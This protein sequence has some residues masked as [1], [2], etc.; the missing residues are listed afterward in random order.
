MLSGD[1]GSVVHLPRGVVAWSAV[2]VTAA[3]T[4]LASRHEPPRTA[5]S[6]PLDDAATHSPSRTPTVR[7]T[8]SVGFGAGAHRG[9]ER[10]SAT[11]SATPPSR[12]RGLSGVDHD[13]GRRCAQVREA[14]PYSHADAGR[15]R[16][17]GER[18]VPAGEPL[19]DVRRPAGPVT[20]T[21]VALHR[22]GGVGSHADGRLRSGGA[23][24]PAVADLVLLARTAVARLVAP[25]LGLSL[26]LRGAGAL[27]LA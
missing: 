10:A 21:S 9:P 6:P 5:S 7:S 22:P 23:P 25:D 13:R 1:D 24:R 12:H 3:A 19:A 4:G 15:E 8:A 18:H 16:G 26:R 11:A 27:G 14:G 17:G 2:L 20:T